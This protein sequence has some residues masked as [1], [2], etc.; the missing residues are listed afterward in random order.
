MHVA[1]LAV[2]SGSS[3]YGD[4]NAIPWH[5]DC[6]ICR[7]YHRKPLGYSGYRVSVSKVDKIP[8]E[9]YLGFGSSWKDIAVQV[10]RD[11][12]ISSCAT[13]DALV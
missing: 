12:K 1:W 13:Y 11:P 5:L 8:M 6:W 10:L 9:A 4:W 2:M 3:Q 7:A